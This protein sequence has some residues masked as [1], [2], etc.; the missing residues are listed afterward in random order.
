[1]KNLTKI[2]SL[3]LVLGML[4]GLM[5]ACN[6]QGDEQL[7]GPATY[8]VKVVDAQGQ[9]YTSGVIVKFMQGGTQA[10]MQPVDANGEAKKEL[11]RGDYTVE[12]V[13]TDE[14]ASGYFDPAT[15]VLS[16]E[17]T[18]LELKLTNRLSE[19]TTPL[20]ADGKDH[21]VYTLEAGSTYVPVTANERNYFLFAPTKAGT[22]K[23][24]TDNEQ[25]AIGYYGAPHFVQSVNAAEMDG[26]TFSMSI[27]ESTLGAVYVI[28]VDGIAEAT[29][30]IVTIERTGDAQISI[31]DLP[32]TEYKT[33]HTPEPYTLNIKDGQQLVYMDIMRDEANHT[34]VY[35]EADGYY[36]LDSADGPVIHVH[37]A[38]GAPYIALQTVIQG[39]GPMGGAPIR[40]Y[41][42]DENGEFVKK[43]DY[44]N[45][46]NQYFE[47]MDEEY[48]VYPLNDDLIY[49]IQNGCHGWWE[50]DS[51]DYIFNDS[52]PELGWMF[53]CC[54]VN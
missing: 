26:N 39:D 44:T 4:C 27:S 21:A 9:P 42:Y 12:L 32:W 13:F 33:T 23:F 46:L 3:V 35:S 50:K 34:F 47:N 1:M 38:K 2:L 43:E 36:H 45:I 8:S 7:S 14:S 49:I 19:E 25:L 37:L 10:A 11:E 30:C 29:N 6:N 16:A 22:Y 51:P 31:S 53:A 17:K 18:S 5:A 20:F 28:G 52:N 24:Y 41:F 15:A 48:G 54:W 40:E